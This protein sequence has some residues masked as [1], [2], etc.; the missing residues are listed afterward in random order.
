MRLNLNRMHKCYWST[1][2]GFLVSVNVKSLANDF[3]FQLSVGIN[4][5]LLTNEYIID[6]GILKTSGGL[7]W[8]SI[9]FTFTATCSN[10]FKK[11]VRRS[12]GE[13]ITRELKRCD[14]IF[15]GLRGLENKD[16]KGRRIIYGERS[17]M[18][19]NE[20]V[21]AV[22]GRTTVESHFGYLYIFHLDRYNRVAGA[23]S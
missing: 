23:M 20:R 15:E 9:I 19:V 1:S 22:E 14:E 21:G 16:W 17:H 12:F 10:G 18:I 5:R 3:Y 13:K 4:F 7:F 6:I 8:K 2:N 11:F